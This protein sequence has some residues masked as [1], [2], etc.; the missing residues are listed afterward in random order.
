MTYSPDGASLYFGL[1]Q[2]N[3]AANGL[4]TLILNAAT[5][6]ARQILAP[7]ITSPAPMPPPPGSLPVTV[8]NAVP[9]LNISTLANATISQGANGAVPV[10]PDGLWIYDLLIISQHQTPSYGVIRRINATTGQTAQELAIQGDFTLARL[11]VAGSDLVVVKGS[12]EAEAF[13]LIPPPKVKVVTDAALGGPGA[14]SGT[15]FSGTLSASISAD[16]VTLYVGQDVTAANGLITGHDLWAVNLGTGTIL[17]H[18]LDINAAGTVLGNG[19]IGDGTL[20]FILRQGQVLV[21][22]PTLK[23]AAK[24]WLVLAGG[25]PVVALLLLAC[26][27]G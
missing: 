10:S 14:P 24:P 18:L 26:A 7:T 3:P 23:G 21:A 9:K 12:P 25:H 16:G 17:S 11:V 8:S 4:R 5:G 22:P 19:V 27:G 6:A 2:A 20:A 1:T 13:L 15:I